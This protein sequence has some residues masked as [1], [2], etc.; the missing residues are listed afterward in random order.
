MA[1]TG[2]LRKIRPVALTGLKPAKPGQDAPELMWVNPLDL[3]VD[4]TYQ[5]DLSE[6]SLRLIRR[7]VETFSWNRF[8]PPIVVRAEGNALH[9][10]DGQ[11]TSIVCASLRIQAIPVMV[12]AA[13]DTAERA[14][15]FVGHNRDRTP[16]SPIDM[17]AALQAAGDEDALDV[18]NVCRRAGVR[19]RHISPGC[20]IAEGD[21]AAVGVV[22][23]L[24][25][26]R[27][28][29]AARKVLDV[30]V[31]AHRAPIAGID[32]LAAEAIFC[33]VAA[34]RPDAD[35]MCL[36]RAIEADGDAGVEAARTSARR[37]GKAQY[38][39]LA[40]RWLR[41]MDEAQS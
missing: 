29:R 33:G 30:L 5:R 35:P 36:A 39:V 40:D 16:V 28:V 12:V 31:A 34:R 19:I 10:I 26:S 9:I 13:E 23:K 27:G 38:Q 22:R 14:R 8:K 37:A 7:L 20:V 24:V 3:M 32:I 2:A 1:E 15:A 11:H 21:T 41:R 6:R 4:A 17:L 18:A 25:K